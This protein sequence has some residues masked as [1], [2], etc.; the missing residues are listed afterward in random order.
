[1]LAS[2]LRIEADGKPLGAGF[3]LA[4]DQR[5][6]TSL[7][8]ISGSTNLQVRTMTGELVPAHMMARSAMYDL[9]LLTTDRTLP[10][11]LD[12]SSESIEPGRLG[13]TL[14]RGERKISAVT[15]R[16]RESTVA[17]IG[18]P[19]VV[20]F[21]LDIAENEKLAPG[22]PF[23]DAAG[24]VQ[25]LVV[26]MCQK[27][28]SDACTTRWMV[29]P[30]TT[31]R[32]FMRSVIRKESAL[33]AS[34]FA[35]NTKTASPRETMSPHANLRVVAIDTGVVRGFRVVTGGVAISPSVRIGDIL[36]GVDGRLAASENELRALLARPKKEG[37]TRI[38]WIVRG[39]A[40]E[41]IRW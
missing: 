32:A 9:A 16:E 28:A 29:L 5:V 31:I 22:A 12:A 4:D 1:M 17:Q 13:Y 15:L 19:P 37:E 36:F 41:A 23:L 8:L 27:T 2:L 40:P 24:A 39:G 20:V 35:P 34:G 38:L 10:H 3:V 25:G 7:S 30:A 21:D 26:H 14:L 6:I 33:G 18:R 11:G